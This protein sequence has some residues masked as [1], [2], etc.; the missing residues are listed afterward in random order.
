EVVA[1][2]VTELNFA[3]DYPVV[4]RALAKFRD[5]RAVPVLQ[6]LLK[7]PVYYVIAALPETL[8]DLGSPKG[9]VILEEILRRADKE[10]PKN[11]SAYTYRNVA[12]LARAVLPALHGEAR[13]VVKLLEHESDSV[14]ETAALYLAARNDM[15]ALPVL[16]R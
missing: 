3:G 8:L 13:H 14:K 15:R 4:M 5:E 1:D 16:V 11:K 12:D 6:K 2:A 10:D 7:E 9:A